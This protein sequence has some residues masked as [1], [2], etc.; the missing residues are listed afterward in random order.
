MK[1]KHFLYLVLLLLVTLVSC[2]QG[3]EAVSV[4]TEGHTDFSV[5]ISAD[6]SD[7]VCYL[8]ESLATLSGETLA[9]RSDDASENKYEI[10][11]GKSKRDLTETYAKEL[12]KYSDDIAIRYVIAEKNGKIIILADNDAGYN[13]A[14]E[15]IASAYMKN[16]AL[17]IPKNCFDVQSVTWSEYYASEYYANKVAWEEEQKRYE[18]EEKQLLDELNRYEENAKNDNVM[19]VAQA[20]E[21]YRN[22]A[23]S[24]S[25]QDFGEYKSVAF[26]NA[27]QYDKP[28][29]YPDEAHPRVMF[30]NNTIETVR[31]NL[32]ADE[33]NTAYAQYMVQSYRP[34]DGIFAPVVGNTHNMDYDVMACIEARAFRYAMTGEKLY[35][36][37]AI[38]C[39]KNAILSLDIPDGTLGDDTRAWGYV[40]YVAGCVYD[41]C[42]DLLTDEDK[43]QI[44]AGCVNRIGVNMEIVNYDGANNT[45]PTAQGPVYGHGGEAQLLR[46]WLTFAIAVS[47]EAPEIYEFVAGR[48]FDQY[49]DMQNYF[50]DSG[51]HWEGS[52]YG[53]FRFHMSLY[54]NTLINRMTNGETDL[55]TDNLEQ[56]A[57][58]FMHYIRPD[59]QPLRIGDVWG[60]GGQ[61]Y[62]LYSYYN[63]AFLAG[64]LYKNS[65]L[66]TFSYK[67]LGNFSRFT[68]SENNISAVML[69]AL[70]D[71]EV[72]HEDTVGITLTRTTSYPFTALF[73]RSSQNDK[74]AFMVYMNM[75]E[76]YGSSHQ[77]MD[78]GS[79]QIYYKG[80]LASD[81]GKY[82]SWGSS[83]HMK[84]NMQTVSSNSILVYNPNLV[85][86][87][88]DA[89]P[90]LIYTG[91]Q[92]VTMG[93]ASITPSTLE[94]LLA[95][96]Q[97]NQCTSLGVANVENNGKYLYSYVGGDMTNAYDSVTVDEVTRYMFAVA[98]GNSSCPL[99][100]VTFD[101][102]TSDDASY[103]KTAL[104]HCQ[105]EPTLTSDGIAII[106]NTSGSNNGKLVVQSVG[107]DTDL[108]I[109]G[110]EGK[111]FWLGDTLGNANVDTSNGGIAEYG[112][113]RVEISP[114]VAE[115]TNHMLTVMYVTDAT[116]NAT[117]TK[118]VDI[119]SENLAGAMIFGKAILF[120][121]NEKLLSTESSFTVNSGA[122]CFVTGVTA[123]RWNVMQGDNLVASVDVEDGTNMFSFKA[124]SAGTYTIIL[125]N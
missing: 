22:L 44:I 101:R 41:W 53:P 24:F 113:G 70:N 112:W 97:F 87:Y 30:T 43:T 56:V 49:R 17:V 13:Y 65:A 68:Y 31:Q 8:A 95:K 99:V 110:G 15:Y 106:T 111:Q 63:M 94:G 23:S 33:N 36:Y 89:Y 105:Y 67:G 103:K 11:V 69:L 50:L 73:A 51:N 62:D 26:V 109:V 10:L 83:H 7:E 102:I 81:S 123:G 42:Y 34:C 32:S 79:F 66:K 28:S 12:L 18:E 45:V 35:G 16:G 84:Y 64:N 107:F 48:L 21:Q 86:T 27:M 115:K 71:P 100:F 19:T 9:I 59:N 90:G 46:D 25:S 98:T 37:Q 1:T 54:A 120:P 3:N 80:I 118:A 38:Y 125:A 121:K 2:K 75:P 88:N 74:N 96:K 114:D 122:E 14:A 124:A 77:H 55:F 61:N 47:T 76:T 6:A 72:S 116:N 93:H 104:I 117:A 78:L 20:I 57:I 58:T 85:G 108:T 29:V 5:V 119:S 92:S 40:M 52:A 39:I 82:S 91:G 4:F 60:E